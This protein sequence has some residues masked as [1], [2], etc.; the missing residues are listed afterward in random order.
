V[1]RLSSSVDVVRRR[2]GRASTA[3]AEIQWCVCGL[4]RVEVT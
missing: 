3:E 1:V 4:C 2:G